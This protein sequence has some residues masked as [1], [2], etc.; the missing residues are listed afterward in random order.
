MSMNQLITD[1]RIKFNL[2]QNQQI[3]IKIKLASEIFSF[4]FGETSDIEQN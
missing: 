3:K 1:Y 2:T 4:L